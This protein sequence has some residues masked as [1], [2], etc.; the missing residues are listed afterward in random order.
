MPKAG[1]MYVFFEVGLTSDL[2]LLLWSSESSSILSL[3]SLRMLCLEGSLGSRLGFVEGSA[4]TSIWAV[5]DLRSESS[6]IGCMMFMKVSSSL[7]DMSDLALILKVSGG[8][9]ILTYGF[10]GFG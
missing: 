2:P 9:G 4:F 5:Q 10:G 1:T 7:T 6:S 8:S 3:I